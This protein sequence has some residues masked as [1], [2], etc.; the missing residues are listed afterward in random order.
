MYE[1]FVSLVKDNNTEGVHNYLAAH[2]DVNVNGMFQV[3]FRGNQQVCALQLAAINDNPEMVTE[4]L[5]YPSID[6]NVHAN[7]GMGL[8]P[9]GW[10]CVLK[11]VG[12]AKVLIS[13]PK[14][15]V[16]LSDSQGNTPFSRACYFGS[17]EIVKLFLNG[18]K[19]DHVKIDQPADDGKTPLWCAARGGHADI[20]QELIRFAGSK[21]IKLDAKAKSKLGDGTAGSENTDAL[22]VAQFW[23]RQ[24]E[25][26]HV[27]DGT[28]QVVQ[29]LEDYLKASN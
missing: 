27:V 28:K 12:V 6:P 16:T 8:T 14:V 23:S 11:H 17:L 10:A 7:S 9:L 19:S 4:L 24:T 18:P 22:E 15:D 5:H 13:D 26:N 25:P 21:G 2:K 20:V 1:E 3:Y 29:I